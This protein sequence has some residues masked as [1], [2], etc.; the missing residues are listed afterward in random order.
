[1]THP[2]IEPDMDHELTAPY[3]EGFQEEEVRLPQCQD[4]NEYVWYPRPIC[5]ACHS[6]SVEWVATSGRAELFT[7]VGM[8]YHFR[9]PFLKDVVP[10]YTG[11]AAPVEAPDVR[12]PVLID[13][14]ADGDPDIGME[15]LPEFL[16][17]EYGMKAP[18]YR[19][20]E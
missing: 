3:W 10:L 5:P 11:L 17:T 4:C 14:P 8:E 2:N 16:E 1:M 19:P 20:V 6:Q 12:I 18:L 15:L 7:W 13:D 9:L